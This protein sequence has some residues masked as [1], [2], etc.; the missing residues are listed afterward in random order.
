MSDTIDY[1]PSENGEKKPVLTIRKQFVKFPGMHIKI[2]DAHNQRL[3]SKAYAVPMKLKERIDI[4]SDEAKTNKILTARATKMIDWNAVFEIEATNSKLILGTLRRNGIK[5]EFARDHWHVFNNQNEPVA[6]LIEDS[7]KMGLLR[8]IAL[9]ILPRTYHLKS[10]SGVVLEIKQSWNPW[11]LK[12]TAYCSNFTK[13]KAEVPERLLIGILTT[14]T[15][16]EGRQR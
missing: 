1:K 16:I 4:Y 14:V 3:L 8:R 13:F 9:G 2:S 5:S 15:V 7:L 11:V 10:H 12:Y 6:E